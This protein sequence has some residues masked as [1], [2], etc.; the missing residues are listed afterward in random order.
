ML[1]AWTESLLANLH[2][3]IIQEQLTL[4]DSDQRGFVSEFIASGPLPDDVETWLHRRRPH[5]ALRPH[6]GGDRHGGYSGSPSLGRIASD[7]RRDDDA[8]RDYLTDR[9]K[10]NDRDKVRIVLE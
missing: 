3:P 2:D 7:H 1:S 8:L 6:Q 4:L 5:L 10:G 9:A